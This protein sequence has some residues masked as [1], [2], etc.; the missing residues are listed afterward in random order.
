[1]QPI[2]EPHVDQA[3][4]ILL[5]HGT[6]GRGFFRRK[7]V[8]PWC[9]PDSLFVDRLLGEFEERIPTVSTSI[10]PVAWCGSNSILCRAKAADDLK[11]QIETLGTDSPILIIGHS[12]GGN[13]VL[14]AS[15]KIRD[16]SNIYVCTLATPFFRLFESDR[17]FA[18]AAPLLRIL[19]TAACMLAATLLVANEVVDDVIIILL[20]FLAAIVFGWIGGNLLYKLLINPAPKNITPTRWQSRTRTL[21]EATLFDARLLRNHLLVLRGIDDEA[22]LSL[23]AGAVANRLL[24]AVYNFSI[25]LVRSPFSKLPYARWIMVFLTTI[26]FAPIFVTSVVSLTFFGP[27]ITIAGVIILLATAALTLFSIPVTRTIFGRE[28]VF[29][30]M[31]CDAFF[32]SVP[33]SNLANVMTLGQGT[34]DRLSHALYENPLA[35]SAIAAWM[36]AHLSR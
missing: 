1:M 10:T 4:K 35:P 5:I 34:E 21:C 13:V 19:C 16:L 3:I 24:R 36:A 12:H 30:A 25:K 8:A 26:Y 18:G 22:G 14:Q 7:P 28:L 29:G 6:W 33:D 23:A 2:S 9:R 11:R 32:D 27:Y 15:S 17:T 20:M 31:G